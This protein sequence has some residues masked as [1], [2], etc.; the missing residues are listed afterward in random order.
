MMA[1]IH[2]PQ[3]QTKQGPNHDSDGNKSMQVD[4]RNDE[5]R[6]RALDSPVR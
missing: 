5:D 3:A 6:D 2:H 1:P 4:S